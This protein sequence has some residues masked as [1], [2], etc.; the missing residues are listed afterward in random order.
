MTPTTTL[1]WGIWRQHRSF[2][3]AIAVLTV[4]GNIVDFL[5]NGGRAAADASPLTVLLAMFAFL[6]LFG[7]FNYTESSGERGLGSFPRRLFVLPVT[8]L[9]L[10]TVPVVAGIASIELL[11]LSW[12]VPLSRGGSLSAPFVAVLFAALM[13]FYLCV[14]WTLERAGSLRLI[15][16]GVIVISVFVVGQ[17]PTF[18]PTP[19]PPWRSEI[20]L[21]GLVAALAV[22]AFLL[23]SRH[24]ARLRTGD[25]RRDGGGSLAHWIA[26]TTPAR[27]SAFANAAAAQFWYEWRTSGM[28]LPVLV[29][30]YVAVFVLPMSWMAR[31]DAADSFRLLLMA[32]GAPIVLAVPVGMAFSRPAFWSND[33][34]VP[35]FV[36]IRPLSAADLVAIK[37]KVAALSALL[38]WAVILLFLAAWLSLW[39][40]VE[41][42]SRF[43]IQIWAFYGQSVAVVYGIGGLVACAGLFLTW[44]SLVTR[45]WSGLSGNRPLFV[46]SFASI[47]ILVLAATALDASKWPGWLR[48]DP[49]R[50]APLAWLA[51]GAVMAKYWLAAYAWRGVA[52]RYVRGYLL[53][54]LAATASFLGL[55]LAVWGIAR[56]YIPLDVDRAR[57]IVILLALLAAPLARVG[58]APSSLARNRHRA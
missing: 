28:V 5:E 18:A 21:A 14:L 17:L 38:S 31:G 37:V 15:T 2:I 47:G 36:A 9:R 56:I 50:L 23:A 32:L 7:V 12:M 51:A 40:N 55:G 52:P 4:A 11:Y 45:L 42:A 20:A 26:E 33:F 39:A 41:N 10:V 57:S 6:L 53:I 43:A 27:R 24:V 16:L 48:D 8:S 54:W 3:A 46:G 1:L 34:D 49:A 35:A 22:V 19:P 44:R 29:A 25:T 58:L 13:V 30:G